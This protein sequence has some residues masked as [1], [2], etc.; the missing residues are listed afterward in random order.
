MSQKSNESLKDTNT[1]KR[2]LF[3]LLFAFAY[4]IA[5]F[6][7]IAVAVVQLLFK[8]ITGSLNE[9]LRVLGKQTARYIYEVMLFLTFNTEEKPF[10][11]AAWPDVDK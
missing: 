7:L 3:M 8:L 11:F 4:S 2:A 9:N 6:V 5:E 1:W 10:P